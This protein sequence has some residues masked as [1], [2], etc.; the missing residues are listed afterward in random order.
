M[1]VAERVISKEKIV[2]ELLE[3]LRNNL[4]NKSKLFARNS[5]DWDYITSLTY[6]EAKLKE[7]LEFFDTAPK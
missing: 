1:S 5:N 7:I 2:K 6:T 3:K 4:N